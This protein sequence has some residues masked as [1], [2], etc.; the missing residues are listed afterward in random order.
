VLFLGKCG[1]LKKTQVGDLILPI[2]AIRGEGTSDDYMPSE[3]PALPSFRLQSTVSAS[4]KKQKLDYWTGTVYTTN[5]RIWEH[6]DSFRF[7]QSNRKLAD[8]HMLNKAWTALANT[9]SASHLLAKLAAH[10][11][12]LLPKTAKVS[13]ALMPYTTILS[14]A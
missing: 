7:G 11:L 1:G 9:S 6:D 14:L 8:A 4:I 2:A 10:Q 13:G 3:I 12:H 5:R